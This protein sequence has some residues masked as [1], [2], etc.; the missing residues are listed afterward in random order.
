MR[1]LGQAVRR[2]GA[3][4]AELPMPWP[5]LG[6]YR[7]AFRRGQASLLAAAPGGGKTILA[8]AYAIESGVPT[9]FVSADTDLNTMAVR[10][11][12]MV[13]GW[14][15]DAVESMGLASVEVQ[16]ALAQIGH[17]RWADDNQ[18][19]V[20][21]IYLEMR[22]YAEVY[23]EFPELVVID[24]L[25]DVQAD[26]QSD[27]DWAGTRLVVDGLKRMARESEAHVLILAHATGAYE[28]GDKPIPLGG[29]EWKPGKNVELVLTMHWG[30]GLELRICPV[31]NRSGR[32][33]ADGSIHATLYAELAH[34][35]IHDPMT[36]KGWILGRSSA[37]SPDRPSLPRASGAEGGT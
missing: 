11:A 27:K 8:L 21:D 18:P 4:A 6:E 17:I 2:T 15:Q 37:Q 7:V 1:A 28:N 25:I 31:K 30:P 24:N 13:T 3:L 16:K 34:C 36:G 26:R 23:G 10:A 35:S 9:L 32:A 29:L 22:A 12:A 33:A 5:S 19:T 14:S 20:E